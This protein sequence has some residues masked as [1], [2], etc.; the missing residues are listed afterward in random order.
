[1]IHWPHGLRYE[2]ALSLAVKAVALAAIGA[3]LFGP[4]DRPAV[5]TATA[6]SHL[7]GG[8]R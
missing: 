6:A 1:M 3:L 8:G 4:A 5:T 7:V 2:L